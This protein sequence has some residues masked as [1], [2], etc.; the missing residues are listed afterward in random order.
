MAAVIQDKA[1]AWPDSFGFGPDGRLCF[2]T[3]RI[4]EGA[5]PREPYGIYRITPAP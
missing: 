4:H 2:T 1:I 5:A 3:S